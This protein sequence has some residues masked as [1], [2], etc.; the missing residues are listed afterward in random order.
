[1]S[2]LFSRQAFMFSDVT[3]QKPIHII[4]L[5]FV[6]SNLFYN[7]AHTGFQNFMLVD[8]D[9]VQE[10]NLLNQLYL[11][12]DIGQPKVYCVSKN[13][14]E[15]VP[16]EVS[17]KLSVISLN[18][19]YKEVREKYFTTHTEDTDTLIVAVDSLEARVEILDYIIENWE[20]KK[21]KEKL[22]I[23]V[24]TSGDLL[25]IGVLR[26]NLKVVK[27]MRTTFKRLIETPEDTD[28]GLCGEKSSY[29]L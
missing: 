1:M 4:G 19:P 29:Y 24:N 10:H 6:G 22:L 14:R 12:R 21:T 8:F 18:A 15:A 7:L 17:K 9:E 13:V 2:N 5:G 27:S 28:E 25:Y 23:F 26:N 16:E 20:E 3:L 11:D